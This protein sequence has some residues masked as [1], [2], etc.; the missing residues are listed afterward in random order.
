[1]LCFEHGGR[2][3]TTVKKSIFNTMSI[4]LVGALMGFTAN[5]STAQAGSPQNGNNGSGQIMIERTGGRSHE[6][7]DGSWKRHNHKFSR[8]GKKH[9]SRNRCSPREAVHKVRGYGLH[10]AEIQRINDRMIVVSGR[11]RGERI[12][13]GMERRSRHCDIAFVRGGHRMHKYRGFR[14]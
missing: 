14:Y 11:K 9:S 8:S 7:Y 2:K 12:L 1:M 13:I 6:R 4:A 3:E 5:V 10:R